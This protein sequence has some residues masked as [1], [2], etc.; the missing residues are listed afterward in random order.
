MYQKKISVAESPRVEVT[1]CRRDLTV[2]AW[3]KSEV[4]A[5]VDDEQTL[6]AEEREGVVAL[7]FN[8][9]GNL[10][11]PA[12]ARLVILQ[13]QGNLSVDGV[14]GALE[15]TTVQGDAWLKE[16][17]G[18]L[19]LKTVQGDLTLEDWAA[20]V[21][22]GTVQGDAGLR[23]VGGDVTVGN[24]GGSLA[25]RK[26]AGAL[27]ADS[28]GGDADLGELDGALSLKNVGGD[29][30]GRDLAAGVDVTHVGGDAS[31]KAVFAGSHTY[32]VQA[33]GDGTIRALPGSAAAFTLRAGGRIRVKGLAGEAAGGE[34]RG[35]L[36]NGEAKVELVAGGSVKLRALGEDVQDEDFPFFDF[37][38][39]GAMMDWG[40]G[41]MGARIQQHV[42]D[43]LSNIDF[44]AIAH[45]EADRARRHM[46]R[47][48]E[49]AQRQREKAQ[50]RAEQHGRGRP[51]GPWH[52]E[53]RVGR[54]APSRG[55][56]ARPS[57]A[58]PE[59]GEQREPAGEE[60]RLAVLK[61]L[62]E[63]KITASEAETL[64]RALGR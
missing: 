52:F 2:T 11:V 62:A 50:R 36:G 43:K 24:V 46:E 23:Q 41:E 12:D 1:S 37:C 51:R 35:T 26:I 19:A 5:E 32:H 10:T 7:A 21:D 20:A 8:D 15:V 30:V 4:L 16:G 56:A 33:G 22:I 57:A 40:M 42:A 44:E 60:E 34:W 38:G 9:E 6:T 13:V 48:M 47:E 49:R 31:L 63:G 29:L 64:L 18:S 53:W 28:V 58:R 25:A 27:S 14:K 59:P 3:D 61:M 54:A 45:R 17:A 55:E 39:M